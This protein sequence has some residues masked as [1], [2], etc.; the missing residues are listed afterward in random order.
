MLG[1]VLLMKFGMNIELKQLSS[2][3]R[4]MYG[5][6]AFFVGGGSKLYKL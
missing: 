1:P 2:E 5:V 6:M 4:N 3:I